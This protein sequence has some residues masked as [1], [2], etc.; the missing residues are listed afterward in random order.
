M[1]RRSLFDAGGHS[2]AIMFNVEV[3]K[4]YDWLEWS[5]VLEASALTLLFCLG[6]CKPRGL[7]VAGLDSFKEAWVV[8]G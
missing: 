4:G 2:R 7:L 8:F 3:W 5:C 6:A 1:L